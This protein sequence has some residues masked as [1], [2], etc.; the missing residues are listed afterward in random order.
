MGSPG[1]RLQTV[2][3]YR[4]LLQPGQTLIPSSQVIQSPGGSQTLAWLLG[5]EGR[6]PGGEGH[7]ARAAPFQLA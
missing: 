2:F 7:Q 1:P 6:G 4:P 3:V 5:L